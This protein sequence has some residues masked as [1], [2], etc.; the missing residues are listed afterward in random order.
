MNPLWTINIFWGPWRILNQRRLADGINPEE[1]I[2]ITGDDD[3]A[4]PGRVSN[5]ESRYKCPICLLNPQDPAT[6]NCG[7][8]YCSN[9]IY[10]ALMTR[11][12]CPLCNA[13]VSNVTRIFMNC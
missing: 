9:C 5:N 6:T 8:V 7:H 10:D 13:R 2:D 3:E 12:S 4:A 1:I 11:V